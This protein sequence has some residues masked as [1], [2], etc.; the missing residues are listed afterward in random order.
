MGKLLNRGPCLRRC[1]TLSATADGYARAEA[2][3]VT[4]LTAVDAA[5]DQ[6]LAEADGAALL[7]LCFVP[8]T[9]VGQDGRSSALTAP[10]G[11]AQQS[12][13]MAALEAAV[14]RPSDIAALQV[15]VC[16]LST[17][18]WPSGSKHVLCLYSQAQRNT[19]G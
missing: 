2:A 8:G 19:V 17:P 1:K 9:A 16:S 10:N 18:S 6:L 7:P 15:W 4:L 3:C 14:L 12:V 11:P 13:I 5:G